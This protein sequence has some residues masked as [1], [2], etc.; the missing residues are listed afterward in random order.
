[1]NKLL[2]ALWLVSLGFGVVAG[3]QAGN[4]DSQ[5]TKWSYPPAAWPM[6][7]LERACAYKEEA[8]LNVL[9]RGRFGE[10]PDDADFRGADGMVFNVKAS[11]TY[12]VPCVEGAG[13]EVRGSD[14]RWRKC[15]VFE[16]SCDLPPHRAGF[17]PKELMPTLANGLW[18]AGRGVVAFVRCRCAKRPRFT[19]GESEPEARS[20]AVDGFEQT[21]LMVPT[22][23]EG[24]WRSNAPLAFR[25]V[26][27]VDSVEEVSFVLDEA[28]PTLQRTFSAG[29]AREQA[30]WSTAAETLRLCTRHFYVDAV[31]RDRLPWAGDLA[32][33]LLASAASFRDGL[34]VRNSLDALGSGGPE[35]GEVNDIVDYS[36][37]W[38]ICH[39]LYRH[40]FDDI[41]FARNRWGWIR[42][43]TDSL[44]R[45]ADADGFIAGTNAWLFID[46][47]ASGCTDLGPRTT[48]LNILQFAALDKAADLAEEL[49][50]GEDAVKWRKQALS[51][52]AN[53]RRAAFDPSRGLFRCDVF[54]RESPFRRHGNFFAVLFGVADETECKRIVDELAKDEM[55]ATGTVWMNAIE[56]IALILHGRGDVVRSRLESIWGG[57]LDRGATTFWE[58]WQPERKG[59]AI[60]NFYNRPFGLALCHATAAGPLFL[61]PMIYAEHPT[62]PFRVNGEFGAENKCAMKGGGVRAK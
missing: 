34:T 36:D 38:V 39:W 61:L 46:H 7:E 24:V 56:G 22:E 53:I 49:G 40:Q 62:N 17:T 21:C 55:P 8:G 41:E 14:G 3:E 58:Q 12:G 29:T 47:G 43:R 33:T 52:R 57:M 10:P 16:S 37:W 9:Y 48:P 1:M 19:V 4:V 30:I 35:C 60:Y 18:D 23:K 31:K 15:D 20:D 51:L 6:W 50:F 44:L 11:T 28:T 2:L 45:L 25:Y 26:R 32:I 59:D 54:D 27:F 42:S 5:K 13:F